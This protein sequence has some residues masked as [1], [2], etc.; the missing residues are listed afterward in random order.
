MDKLCDGKQL[1]E[2]YGMEV[3]LQNR[4]YDIKTQVGNQLCRQIKDKARNEVFII[5]WTKIQIM[6]LK[7][8]RHICSELKVI[9]PGELG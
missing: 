5:T 9:Y 3:N 6:Q 1:M 7:I 4:I 2:M 8:I